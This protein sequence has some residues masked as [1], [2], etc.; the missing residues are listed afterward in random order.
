[1]PATTSSGDKILEMVL[2]QERTTCAIEKHMISPKENKKRTV[3]KSFCPAIRRLRADDMTQ[4]RRV[5]KSFLE[6]DDG[7]QYGE[8]G[9]Q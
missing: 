1:M 9:R 8:K 2:K 6:Q 3:S 4:L 7:I 5:D